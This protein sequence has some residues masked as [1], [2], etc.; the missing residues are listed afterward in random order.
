MLP[1]KRKRED[2]DDM[3]CS[4]VTV[5]GSKIYAFGVNVKTL[6]YHTTTVEMLDTV[7]HKHTLLRGLDGDIHENAC[8]VLINEKIWVIGGPTMKGGFETS[9]R[10]NIYDTIN[11]TW[12][13]RDDWTLSVEQCRSVI[14]LAYYHQVTEKIIIIMGVR[15]AD[16]Y[17][18]YQRSI[19]DNA[20]DKTWSKEVISSPNTPH[21]SA[22]I[23]YL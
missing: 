17:T 3:K 6:L 11:N 8:T 23:S 14:Y 1:S 7:T 9:E 18:I 22:F 13:T 10:I 20:K 15:N 4:A 16:T 19:H 21:L 2:Y 12:T 5:I